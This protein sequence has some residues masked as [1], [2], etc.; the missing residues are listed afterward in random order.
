MI[1]GQ[2]LDEN[3]IMSDVV[4]DKMNSS[5]IWVTIELKSTFKRTIFKIIFEIYFN[6]KQRNGQIFFHKV[7]LSF[8]FLHK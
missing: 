1:V 2:I 3:E 8:F 6:R 7:Q 4:I 5:N